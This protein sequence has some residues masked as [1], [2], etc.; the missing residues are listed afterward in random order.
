MRSWQSAGE[1]VFGAFGITFFESACNDSIDSVMAVEYN[2]TDGTAL[3]ECLAMPDP[4]KFS[5]SAP[6]VFI[7]PD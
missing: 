2:D 4:A 7:F 1:F 3:K 5:L 6:A